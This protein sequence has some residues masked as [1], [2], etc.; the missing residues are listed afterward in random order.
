MLKL[1]KGE[2]RM[3]PL[4]KYKSGC[5]SKFLDQDGCRGINACMILEDIFTRALSE[6]PHDL[7]YL[8]AR[9][10]FRERES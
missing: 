2:L 7:S 10:A 6:L 1:R 3:W 8:R 5:F 9:C 4:E